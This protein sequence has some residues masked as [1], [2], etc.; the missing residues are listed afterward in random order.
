MHMRTYERMYAW[1]YLSQ[2]NYA[3][4]C[5]NKSII[6]VSQ[7][8]HTMFVPQHNSCSC[9]CYVQ[10]CVS[11]FFFAPIIVFAPVLAPLCF[12]GNCLSFWMLAYGHVVTMCLKT[13]YIMP[14]SSDEMLS[15]F[16]GNV[17]NDLNDLL[18]IDE[19]P[20]PDGEIVDLCKTE[21][22]DSNELATYL[23]E[24]RNHFN[25]LSLNTQSIRA[26][27]D[28]LCVI[29]SEL[30]EKELAFSVIC[31]QES[32][33]KDEDDVSPYLLPG[34]NLINQPAVCSKHGGLMIC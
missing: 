25:I 1:P 19:I 17:R 26:K 32:W 7:S 2:L 29:L 12:V 31:F 5:L 13:T 8:V 20:D 15:Q 11:L 34:Y 22:I 24:H 3:K 21:Y 16:G 6:L 10:I 9:L 23:S 27:F 4:T 18:D 14:I 33:L 28:Q 30:Y